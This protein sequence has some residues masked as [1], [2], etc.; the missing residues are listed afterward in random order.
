MLRRFVVQ[1]FL[2]ISALGLMVESAR[3]QSMV[4]I[5][6]ESILKGPSGSALTEAEF[7]ERMES[8]RYGTEPITD[9]SGNVIGYKLVRKAEARADCGA[10]AARAMQIQS[11][12]IAEAEPI[13]LIRYHYL[14]LPIDIYDGEAWREYLVVLDTGTYIPLILDPELPFAD[15]KRARVRGIEFSNFPTG[16]FEPFELIRGMNRFREERPDL[17][18]D[19]R[20]VGIAG[21]S[22]FQNYL[23]S[24]DASESRLILRPLDSERRR[25][26][27][28]EP[29]VSVRYRAEQSNIWIPVTLNGVEGFAHYDTGSPYTFVSGEILEQR[30]GRLESMVV[31]GVELASAYR[32]RPD[33]DAS[34]VRARDLGPAY[35]GV[36]L[37]VIAQLGCEGTD[38]WIVTLDTHENRVYFESR[39]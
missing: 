26:L 37:D 23:T 8:G 30:Q 13:D 20:I 2:C 15:A 31:A 1:G 17:F 21:I 10:E 36:P 19:R 27:E 3:A 16:R 14:F 4:T 33:A 24:I 9:G 34:V 12:P 6:D 35:Q 7:I 5:D 38:R 18:G 32:T 25:L 39:P 29:V 11:T 28:D 22:L